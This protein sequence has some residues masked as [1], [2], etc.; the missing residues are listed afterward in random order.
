[1]VKLDTIEKCMDLE[2]VWVEK[3]MTSMESSKEDRMYETFKVEWWE[4]VA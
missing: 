1:M 4:H 2:H 3:A